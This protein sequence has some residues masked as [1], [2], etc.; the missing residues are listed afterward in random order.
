[1][2]GKITLAFMA[3]THNVVVVVANVNVIGIFAVF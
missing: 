3:N 2:V 1:M